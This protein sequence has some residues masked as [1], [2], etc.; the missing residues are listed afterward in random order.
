M[1]QLVA[2]ARARS[3]I[4]DACERLKRQESVDD[5]KT[6][7]GQSEKVCIDHNI[8][9]DRYFMMLRLGIDLEELLMEQRWAR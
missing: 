1:M 4:S 9:C 2:R 3:C 6:N 5:I 7:F 8:Y